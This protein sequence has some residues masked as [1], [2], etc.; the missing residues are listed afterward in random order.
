MGIV[1]DSLGNDANIGETV[2]QRMPSC[3]AV[4]DRFLSCR[5]S[6]VF[7]SAVQSELWLNNF[8][9]GTSSGSNSANQQGLMTTVGKILGIKDLAS[10]RPEMTLADLGLDSLMGV[11]IK[12]LLE[13]DYNLVMTNAERQALS[14][15]KLLEISGEKTTST[16]T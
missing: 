11:E 10:M 13:R 1:A 15:G 6:T 3:L 7:L 12:Q 14:I 2:P 8:T 5:T 9:G 16:S 4:L